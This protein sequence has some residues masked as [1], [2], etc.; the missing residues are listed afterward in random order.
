MKKF[1]LLS[2]TAL[3]AM[4]PAAFAA[5]IVPPAAPT[6][7]AFHIGIG[8][9]AGYNVYDASSTADLYGIDPEDGELIGPLL[10]QSINGNDLGSWYGFGTVEAGFDYQFE[11]TGF[12]IGILGSYDFNGSNS[13]DATNSLFTPLIEEGASINSKVEAE[14]DDSWFLGGRLGFVMNDDTLIYG[15]GGYTW[16]KGKVKS[17]HNILVDEG[18][19]PEEFGGINSSDSDNVDGWTLGAGIEHLLTENISLKLEYRH[20]FL[21]D[22]QV[23]DSTTFVDANIGPFDDIAVLNDTKVDFSR[24]TVR[25]VLSWRFNPG[26]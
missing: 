25:A 2:A 15:L 24:D 12:V 8:G 10:S 18:N 4:A 5:D 6:W 3:V 13:A 16:V 23:N 21:N 14:L 17:Q 20:D 11:D 7:T 22:I 9:G 26:W 1:L 19:G